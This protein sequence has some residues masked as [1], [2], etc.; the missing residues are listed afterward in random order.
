MYA[1]YNYGGIYLDMD[2]EVLKCFD[3]LLELHT[4]VC[5][6]KEMSGLEVAAFGSEKHA[7]WLKD[8]LSY[9]KIALLSKMMALLI[10]KFCLLL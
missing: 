4:F 6:Q 9:Y 8:C 5:W 2:V 3:P 7:E 1:L 10:Q